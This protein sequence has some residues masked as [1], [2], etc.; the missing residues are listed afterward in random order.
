MST[1]SRVDPPWSAPVGPTH[2]VVQTTPVFAAVLQHLNQGA[3]GA[4]IS[5]LGPELDARCRALVDE[6][7]KVALEGRGGG[8]LRL[9][10]ILW[11]LALTGAVFFALGYWS[12][13]EGARAA[14][15]APVER[16]APRS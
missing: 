1:T 14:A 4:L 15:S 13:R 9:A 3:T 8:R 2:R 12:A 16:A 7:L 11:V 5:R 6:R 10:P